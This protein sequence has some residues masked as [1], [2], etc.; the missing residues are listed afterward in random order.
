M[1]KY[2]K[3]LI[4]MLFMFYLTA[5][6]QQD[7]SEGQKKNTGVDITVSAAAS[8]NNAL[9]EIKT[10]F[11]KNNKNI[12]ISTNLGGTGALQQQIIQGAPVDIFISAA[13]DKFV[14]LI[15]KGL[16]SKDKSKDLLGNEL[17]LITN[18][19]NP[20]PIHSLEDLADSRVK[21]I[22]IG[23]PESVPAGQYAMQTLRKI[24][25]SKKIQPKIV[26]TK[27]VRQVLTYVETGSVDA[28][29]VYTTDAKISTKVKTVAVAPSGSHDPIIYPAGIINES[30][31]KKEA[32]I[33]FEFLQSKTA[34]KIFEK[35]GFNVLE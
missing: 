6:S 35:Y 29:L 12:H 17:V 23:I 15:N 18:K 11:E 9:K 28:G 27:D 21:K 22:A 14:T 8:L 33:F 32:A 31:H 30:K 3:I 13:K 16:I 4:A 5:C 10:E 34:K 7:S 26:Q 24:R 2:I 25:I 1:N 20:A 19:Q